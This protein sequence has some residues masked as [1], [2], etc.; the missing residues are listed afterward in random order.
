MWWIADENGNYFPGV[1]FFFFSAE[2]L[3]KK[4]DISDILH[5]PLIFDAGMNTKGLRLENCPQEGIPP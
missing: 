2:I 1:E 3:I 4:A 5:R